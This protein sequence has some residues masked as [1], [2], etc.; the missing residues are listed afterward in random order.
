MALNISTDSKADRV[1]LDRW[2][3]LKDL[4]IPETDVREVHLLIGL[5][6]PDLPR[7]SE[8]RYGG[9]GEPFARHTPLGW[10]VN[11][12]LGIPSNRS[13]RSHF[14][15]VH[16]APIE[17]DLARLW[18]MEGSHSEEQG[19]S[20]EDRRVLDIWKQSK[21]LDE[22]RHSMAIP[23]KTEHLKL[24]DNRVMAEKR[25]ESLRRRLNKDDDLR[26]RYTKEIKKLLTKGYAEQ[27]SEQQLQRVDG[28]VWYLPHQPV[29]NPKK[30]GKCRIVNDGGAKYCGYSLN[31]CVMQGPDLTNSLVG[32]LLRFRQGDV[33]FMADIEAMFMQVKVQEEDRDVL[34][35]LWFENH[36][37]NAPLMIY[38]MTTHL[39]GG[40]WSPSCANYA[41]RCTAEDFKDAYPDEVRE[42]VRRNFYVDDCLKSRDDAGETTC[43]V[44]A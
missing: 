42:T 39:F 4:D 11:G 10:A 14:V 36:D 37:T 44:T 22:G 34:R 25:V 7:T 6:C 33:A 32:V 5:D 27:F 30:P 23:F 3:H 43:L 18:D 16:R 28:R 29:V 38:R 9:K 15:S 8:E 13:R 1:D 31:D 12:P 17:H 41:L 40:V 26:E 20:V 24:D 35:F 2:P 21:K 19:L